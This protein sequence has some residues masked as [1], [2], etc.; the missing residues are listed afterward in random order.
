MTNPPFPRARDTPLRVCGQ[1]PGRCSLTLG[2]PV[3]CRF[4]EDA[5]SHFCLGQTA[6]KTRL[7]D[8]GVPFLYQSC[9]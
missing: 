3:E 1:Q 4:D 6:I 2:E 9:Q 7:H 5:G 8:F